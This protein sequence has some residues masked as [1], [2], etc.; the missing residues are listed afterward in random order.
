M[1]GS[2]IIYIPFC[3]LDSAP[4]YKIKK[5]KKYQLP[6]GLIQMKWMISRKIIDKKWSKQHLINHIKRAWEWNEG[7]SEFGFKGEKPCLY[8]GKRKKKVG[9]C[10]HTIGS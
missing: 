5:K 4:T 9:A 6:P 2:I 3:C 10:F 8:V 7:H 1:D